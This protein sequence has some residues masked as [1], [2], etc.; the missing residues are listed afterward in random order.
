MQGESR[1]HTADP[2]PSHALRKGR[3][4]AGRGQGWSRLRGKNP[5]ALPE[6]FLLGELPHVFLPCEDAW[7]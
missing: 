4:G 7:I 1:I 3:P 2:A 5:P 6:V